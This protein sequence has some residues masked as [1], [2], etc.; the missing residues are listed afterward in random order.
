M[1]TESRQ[2]RARALAG[3]LEPFAGQVHF[4]PECHAEYLALGFG[5]SS[6]MA[7]RTQLPDRDAY[8]T[9]R[10]SVMGQ[11][12]G[13][14]VAAA[15]AVFNPDVLAPAVERGWTKTDAATICEARRRGAVAQ[16]R[17]I[18]GAEP[19]DVRRVGDLLAR[20]LEPL[21][22]EGRPL[23]AG[24][25][26][27][28]LPAEPLARAWRAADALRE[29]RGDSHT[30]TWVGAGLDPVEIGMLSDLYWRTPVRGHTSGRGWTAEQMDGALE[31]LCARGL[32]HEDRLTA[33]GQ[34]L[35]ETIERHTDDQLAPAVAALGD[36]VDDLV[37]VLTPWGDA[38]RAEGGYL[39]PA[40]RFTWLPDPVAPNRNDGAGDARG[41]DVTA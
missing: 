30:L 33:D 21:P 32:V 23:F 1:E 16:L 13:T 9:S 4:S 11:A 12:R 5:G 15:F 31:R 28:D 22:T 14:V 20:A 41:T 38:I 34:Q 35:R 3:A 18:L 37:A 7:G 27:D 17:R 39:S 19:T 10:G 25:R 36:D 26:A 8:F 6:G 40:V 24:Q 2:V 29:Y